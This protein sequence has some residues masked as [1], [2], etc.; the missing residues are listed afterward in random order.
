VLVAFL[1][2]G[3]LFITLLLPLGSY[4]AIGLTITIISF[5]C[6]AYG[7]PDLGL[8]KRHCGELVVATIRVG[9]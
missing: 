9:D 5:S 1:I 6:L 3:L 8:I 7:L 2:L 4:Q